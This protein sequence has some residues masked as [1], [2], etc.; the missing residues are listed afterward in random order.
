MPAALRQR[1]TEEATLSVEIEAILGNEELAALLET[2]EASSQLR[3]AELQEALEPLDLDPLETDAVYIELDRR[4][5]ELVEDRSGRPLLPHPR[6]SRRRR[7]PT[8]S[9]SSCAR[10]AGMPC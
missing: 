6:P 2:A 9:S 10:P 1:R 5:I 8:R 7:R 3:Y 4:G